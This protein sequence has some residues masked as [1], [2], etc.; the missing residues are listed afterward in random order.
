M[1]GITLKLYKSYTI[2]LKSGCGNLYTTHATD[3][4]G[5]HEILLTLGKAGGCVAAHLSTFAIL[6]TEAIN[7]DNPLLI[8]SKCCGIKCIYMPCCIDIASRHFID[9]ILHEKEVI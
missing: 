3:V 7:N 5:K 4:N 1:E 9:F 6:L 8:L 2:A